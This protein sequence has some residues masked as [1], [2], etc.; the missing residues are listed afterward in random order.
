LLCGFTENGY[1]ELGHCNG[2]R[3]AQF[4]FSES[5]NCKRNAFEERFAFYFGRVLDTLGVTVADPAECHQASVRF[6][7]LFASDLGSQP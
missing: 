3:R 4:I 6:R 5:S 2:F 1:C 7:C